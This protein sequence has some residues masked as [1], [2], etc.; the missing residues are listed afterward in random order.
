M[1]TAIQ[2]HGQRQNCR[3]K[4]LKLRAVFL[5]CLRRVADRLD[6][7]AAQRDLDGMEKWA[8]GNLINSSK[9]NRKALHLGWNSLRSRAGCGKA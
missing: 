2:I 7:V 4:K 5:T 6:R 8:D 1:Q 3:L 9:G